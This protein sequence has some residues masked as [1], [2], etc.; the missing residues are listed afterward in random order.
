M[1]IETV[2]F[3]IGLGSVGIAFFRLPYK[4]RAYILAYIVG[5][6]VNIGTTIF[7]LLWVPIIG[8]FAGIVFCLRG[9]WRTQHGLYKK[10]DSKWTE[11]EHL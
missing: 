9:W 6:I 3:F 11:R 10:I 4:F 2:F 7:I 5:T 8:F 1:T